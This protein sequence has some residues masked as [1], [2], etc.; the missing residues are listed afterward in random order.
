[1]LT[2]VDEKNNPKMVDVSPKVETNRYAYARC[3]VV[4]PPEIIDLFSGKEI[5]S[6]KGPVFQTAIIA[7]TMALKQTSALIP[8]CHQLNI[9]GSKIEIKMEKNIAF[10]DCTVK[11]F[12]KTGV[13][14]EALM[15][16][17]IAALTIYD[18]CK[19]ISQNIVIDNLHLVKKKGGKSDY[20]KIS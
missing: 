2:H 13:E 17:Q 12:G 8:F 1:M 5:H 14:M 3:H 4:L 18:M 15:G 16:A 10:V 20:H 7:G 6:K 9:E 11:C 19:A